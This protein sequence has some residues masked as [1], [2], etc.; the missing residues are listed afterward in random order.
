M[1]L[2]HKDGSSPGGLWLQGAEDHQGLSNVLDLW[3]V[4]RLSAY[5]SAH[6]WNFTKNMVKK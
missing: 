1:P 2:R 6:L 5:V 3:L 4:H